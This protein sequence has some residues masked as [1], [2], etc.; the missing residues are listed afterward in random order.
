MALYTELT[1]LRKQP[2]EN[3]TDYMIRAENA[4][5]FLKNV[6]ETISRGLLI[7]MILK[8]L[9]NEYKNLH[10]CDDTERRTYDVPKF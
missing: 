4:A 1:L 6:G 9:P 8:G 7:T 2:E 3:I 10:Y 5:T